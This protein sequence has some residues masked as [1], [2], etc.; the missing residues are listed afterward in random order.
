[1][2][3]DKSA[4]VTG[5]STGIGHATADLLSK[6]GWRVFAG[7]RKEADAERLL[8]ELGPQVT[9]L[10]I[11]V[12]DNDTCRAAADEARAMLDGRNLSGLVNNAGV[13]VAGPLLHLPIEDMTRQLDINVTGQL[14]VTQAVAPLLGAEAGRSGPPGRIVN[15]SSVAAFNTTPVI[16]PYA[17]SKRAL[18]A[19]SQGLRRE[20]GP[21][22]V[23]VVSIN[24]GPVETPIWDKAEELDADRYAATDYA[25]AIAI[26]RDFMLSRGARGLAPATVAEAVHAA[27]TARRPKLNTVVTGEPLQQ[28]LI[29][30]LPERLVDRLTMKA[31]RLRPR[32]RA[33][34]TAK[35]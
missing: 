17:A 32:D 8:A 14:R 33:A 29:G 2:T 34:R 27:L 19:F 9:P 15:I 4:L 16:T 5:A 26:I 30:L 23:D 11:D 10:I 24:P 35:D 7:V 1:M 22:G 31:L 20:L 13:A 28:A 6:R 25:P 18:E 12:T 3:E 21:Y